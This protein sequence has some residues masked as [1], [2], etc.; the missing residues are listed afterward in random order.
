MKKLLSQINSFYFQPYGLGLALFLFFWI[1]CF[2]LSGR[3]APVP[4]LDPSWNVLLENTFSKGSVWGRDVIFT[5]GPLGWLAATFS[6]G[7]FVGPRF[8]AAF[9][10]AIVWAA[11]FVWLLK[12]LPLVWAIL[13]GVWGFIFLPWMETKVLLFFLLSGWILTRRHVHPGWETTL[14]LFGSLFALIKFNFNL[15]FIAV[16]GLV[17]L[18]HL[19]QKNYWRASR[20]GLTAV[21]LWLGAWFLSGQSLNNIIPYFYSSLQISTGYAETMS[22]APIPGVL[23]G[24]LIALS[25]CLG[26]L[27]L[28]AGDIL[29]NKKA[30]AEKVSHVLVVCVLPLGLTFFAWKHGFTRA[31]D[32]V[33][34]FISFLPFA[35]IPAFLQAYKEGFIFRWSKLRAG[36]VFASFASLIVASNLQGLWTWQNTIPRS[37]GAW[38]NHAGNFQ[39]IA[40]ASFEER[41]I[42]PFP[43][44][45]S[46]RRPTLPQARALIG[47]EFVD[48]YN[49]SIGH[50]ILN[51]LNIRHRPVFQSYSAYTPWLQKQNLRFLEGDSAPTYILHK[52]ESVDYRHPALDDAAAQ[53]KL[54]THYQPILHEN[55]FL[56]LERSHEPGETQ[57]LSD[58]DQKLA[59]GES[60]ILPTLDSDF[61]VLKV[62]LKLSFL[63]RLRKI[64]YQGPVAQIIVQL[65][66]GFEHHLRFPTGMA[67]NGMIINPIPFSAGDIIEIHAHQLYEKVKSVRFET[68]TPNLFRGSPKISLKKGMTPSNSVPTEE[69]FNN[70]LYPG[71]LSWVSK[72][73]ITRGE[74][75]ITSIVAPKKLERAEFPIRRLRWNSPEII[76][77][78]FRYDR[79]PERFENPIPRDNIFWSSFGGK[80]THVGTLEFLIP[81][82]GSE[83]WILLPY[84]TGPATSNLTLEWIDENSQ[85]RL[86]RLRPESSPGIWRIWPAFLP[87]RDHSA[88]LRLRL[89]DSGGGW[90][91]W[92]AAAQPIFVRRIDKNK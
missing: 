59:W 5:F 92:L 52:L 78:W 41:Q 28:S 74:S 71:Y 31:D 34:S 37:V 24:S 25:L 60:L 64:F 14:I 83:G 88:L 11:L 46:Y 57:P 56:L 4:Y 8:V 7:L 20:L 9:I 63:G 54:L 67:E 18:V 29:K 35:F 39:R 50:L 81:W 43:E 70:L 79:L 44:T 21:V 40:A 19:L 58:S 53:I 77:N 45:I 10:F 16:G 12:S 49:Y 76:Q 62:E 91:E 48:L 73:P 3:F 80:D 87:A 55:S 36:L 22:I 15:Q 17:I 33:Y 85:A 51:N 68:D 30:P 89:E 38:F 61:Q 1:V 75:L 2:Q 23:M 26:V 82:D 66:N 6:D 86:T 13:F 42:L 72:L 90:G 27:S 32:H 84:T 47:N 69:F 65:E